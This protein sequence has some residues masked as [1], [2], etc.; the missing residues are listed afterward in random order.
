MAGYCVFPAVDSASTGKYER[1]HT[2]LVQNGQFQAMKAGG[3]KYGC[4]IAKR[5]A[6]SPPPALI[7]RKLDH[8][9]LREH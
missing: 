2:V 7:L 6:L 8:P 9:P 5:C 3:I 4:H 1:V